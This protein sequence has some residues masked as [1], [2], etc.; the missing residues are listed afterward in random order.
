MPLVPG[1][2]YTR[3]DIYQALN[4]PVDKRRGHWESGLHYYNGENFIFATM[5]APTTTGHDYQNRWL[6]NQFEWFGKS[7]SIITHLGVSRLF[8]P[9]AV[10]HLFTKVGSSST[11]EYAG[12]VQASHPESQNPIRV[13]W[14]VVDSGISDYPDEVHA[15]VTTPLFEGATKQVLVNRYERNIEARKACIVHYGGPTCQICN[16]NFSAVY[17][18]EGE[19]LIHVHHLKLL[20]SIGK[21]YKINPVKDLLPVCPNC[22]AMLHRQNPPY[23]PAQVRKMLLDNS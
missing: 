19:G 13:L 12:Q 4:V 10:N 20:S 17:G 7:G 18:S 23:T 3:N 5:E 14:N 2:L 22:H 1:Q 15:S 6:D 21:T 8:E 9:N 11:F 16:F